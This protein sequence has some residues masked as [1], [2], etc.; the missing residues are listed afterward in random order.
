MLGVIWL[1][2]IVISFVCSLL[3][4]RVEELSRAAIEGADKAIRLIISMA[5][6]MCLWTGIVKI[7]DSGGLTKVMAKILSPVLG[8][9]MPEY[10]KNAQTMG[11]ISANVTANILGLG[12]AATPLGVAAMKEMQK[13][14]HLK[15]SPNNSMVMFVVINTA[16]VQLVPTTIAAMRQA[17]GSVSP[18]SIVPYVWVTSILSLAAGL[19]AAKLLSLRS[20]ENE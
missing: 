1:V 13:T 15:T 4:G 5:G 8:L 12:N 17:A 10:R 6:S 11:A 20:G 2:M 19:L 3:T 7:A 16:S 14:N 18:Y 9:L